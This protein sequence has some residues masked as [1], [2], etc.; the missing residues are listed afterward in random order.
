MSVT[1]LAE[2]E[3]RKTRVTRWIARCLCTSTQPKQPSVKVAQLQRDS[4]IRPRP[5]KP[6]IELA[7]VNRVQRGRSR[8]RI[9]RPQHPASRPD[10]GQMSISEAT[11][12]QR[13]SRNNSTSG[14]PEVQSPDYDA[15]KT[16]KGWIRG[17]NKTEKNKYLPRPLRVVASQ[18]TRRNIEQN[19]RR[20]SGG[21]GFLV[22]QIPQQEELPRYQADVCAWGRRVSPILGRTIHIESSEES[23]CAQQAR[24][25]QHTNSI[26]CRK[27]VRIA[28]SSR[29]MNDNHEGTRRD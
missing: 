24:A 5:D 2:R 21:N 18:L 26:L 7:P 1:D 13:T 25:N 9:N 17:Q 28:Y 20:L 22:D 6:D 23:L 3:K 15:P 11:P 19:E 29:P 14:R 16:Y 8:Y 27:S 12:Y 4:A 10:L